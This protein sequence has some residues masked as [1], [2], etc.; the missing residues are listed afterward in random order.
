[1]AGATAGL[2]CAHGPVSVAMVLHLRMSIL[3]RFVYD[4]HYTRMGWTG[5]WF[6][7]VEESS[8]KQQATLCP[9]LHGTTIGRPSIDN[10]SQ[11]G[12][13]RTNMP[14]GTA[15]TLPY[16]LAH[17]RSLELLGI[18]WLCMWH[19]A[20]LAGYHC[21]LVDRP[22]T[23]T[24]GGHSLYCALGHSNA[25]PSRPWCV[26]IRA[27]STRRCMTLSLT[28][29]QSSPSCAMVGDLHWRRRLV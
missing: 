10:G 3:Q 21:L 23:N 16:W 9:S 8:K 19:R 17:R 22:P 29:K 27:L 15:P 26:G 24:L 7:L 6:N 2:C 1:M 25:T 11:W 20:T 18:V 13:S 12:F 5:T 28:V 14:S 4:E